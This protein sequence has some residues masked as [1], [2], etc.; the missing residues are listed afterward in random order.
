MATETS[1]TVVGHDSLRVAGTITASGE[2]IDTVAITYATTATVAGVSVTSTLVSVT[3]VMET[4]ADT[5]KARADNRRYLSVRSTSAG[6]GRHFCGCHPNRACDRSQHEV[7]SQG[8]EVGG[9]TTYNQ[10][11]DRTAEIVASTSS[12]GGGMSNVF[13]T[14]SV[15]DSIFLIGNTRQN[16]R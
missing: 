14:A 8:S 9:P 2:S 3:G 12:T 11:N 1:G 16:C 6:R 15:G 5:S 4:M 7:S 13:S 10:C